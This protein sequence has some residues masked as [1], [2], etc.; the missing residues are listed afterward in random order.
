MAARF[1]QVKS[2]AVVLVA[3]FPCTAWLWPFSSIEGGESLP[4]V[5]RR[6]SPS[7]G[8]K[9][10]ACADSS[11]LEDV[12]RKM[13]NSEVLACFLDLGEDGMT[14]H[15]LWTEKLPEVPSFDAMCVSNL[16]T[17][18]LEDAFPPQLKAGGS[19]AN[20]GQAALVDARKLARIFIMSQQETFESQQLRLRLA[21]FDH[22][23]CSRLHWDDVPLRLV[24]TLT[25]A[26][27][28]VLPEGKANRASFGELLSM[29][30]ERQAELTSQEWNERVAQ[31]EGWFDDLI[32]VPAGWGVLLKGSAWR[33]QGSCAGALHCSPR[34]AE[35]RVIL[36]V[37]LAE[38]V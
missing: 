21:C 16:D 20:L 2:K 8:H 19:L 15:D 28:E 3:L 18:A 37:D 35:K 1:R 25:G 26:G 31:G 38:S 4:K 12:R 24:C 17:L 30:V 9:G 36:Q 22:V 10:T 11:D 7:N 33:G 27:T 23:P 29:P 6:L 13:E 32:P 5:R 34:Q 14:S